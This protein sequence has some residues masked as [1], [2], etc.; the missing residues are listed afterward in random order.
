MGFSEVP[1]HAAL[2]RVWPHNWDLGRTEEGDV[3]R[4]ERL[5]AADVDGLLREFPLE[6]ASVGD[7]AE[8]GVGD[9][10]EALEQDA[11]VD[12]SDILR[13]FDAEVRAKVEEVLD[14]VQSH[15]AHVIKNWHPFVFAPELAIDSSPGPECRRLKF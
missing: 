11:G 4:Y 13:D 14:G 2:Q 10:V 5:G 6:D 1:G 9:W 3:V 7:A 8:V 12:I 15:A